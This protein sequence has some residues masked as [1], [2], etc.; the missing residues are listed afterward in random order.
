MSEEDGQSEDRESREEDPTNRGPVESGTDPPEWPPSQTLLTQLTGLSERVQASPLSDAWAAVSERAAARLFEWWVDS[1]S[2]GGG[3][4]RELFDTRQVRTTGESDA[5]ESPGEAE[6]AAGSTDSTDSTWVQFL[7][8][9]GALLAASRRAGAELSRRG[10]DTDL[11]FD[12]LSEE[13]RESVS[14]RWDDLRERY[15]NWTDALLETIID[16]SGRQEG[17]ESPG[18]TVVTAS[19]EGSPAG[20]GG[21]RG[22]GQWWVVLTG[23]AADLDELADRAVAL[24]FREVFSEPDDSFG[25]DDSGAHGPSIEGSPSP[26]EAS[27]FMRALERIMMEVVDAAMFD[28]HADTASDREEDRDDPATES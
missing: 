10:D 5:S 20:G 12:Q 1:G 15:P 25:T 7:G 16:E 14:Q 8:S 19:D 11:G 23:E 18:R 28:D 2:E 3:D 4:A 27:G 17:F 24:A 9:A 26:G 21:D 22:E 6:G 13:A